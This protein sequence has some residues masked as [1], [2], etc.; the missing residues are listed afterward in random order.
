[1]PRHNFRPALRRLVLAAGLSIVGSLAAV[2]VVTGPASVA[3]SAEVGV[4]A[5]WASF[6]WGSNN[7]GALGLGPV[8]S[9]NVP[10]LVV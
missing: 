8:G 5:N 9:R 1:M 2:V 7:Q 4:Q 10:T 3:L 6:C